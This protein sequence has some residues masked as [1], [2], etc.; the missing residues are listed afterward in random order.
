MTWQTLKE[1]NV[2]FFVNIF[3][4][5][6]IIAVTTLFLLSVVED[7]DF[8]WHLKTGEWIW[9]NKALPS[10]DP[11]AYTTP[12][13]GSA[14]EHAVLTSYWI[15]QVIFHLMHSAAGIS[16]I[17]FLRFLVF[18]A[19]IY[20]MI[21]RRQGDHTLYL[22]LLLIFVATFLQ[23]YVMDR[24]QVFSFLFFG[25]LLLILD[26]IGNGAPTGYYELPI[27]ML[28]WANS[29]GGF[30]LGQV[31]IALYMVMEGVKF[32]K[33][34]MLRPMA[35]EAYKKL[36]LTGAF[37]IACSFVNPNTYHGWAVFIEMPSFMTSQIVEYW[38]TIEYF[39][40]FG[41][42]GIL[43]YWLLLLLT[44]V[45]ILVNIKKIDITE[46]ALLAATGYFS[47]T[48]IRY[49]AFFLIAAVPAAGRLFS[50]NLVLPWAR[51]FILFA[52]I[53]IS[54]FFSKGELH[55]MKN[56][57]SGRWISDYQFPVQAAEFVSSHKLMGNMYNDFGWGGYL[58]WRLGPERK[59]F[60]DGRSLSETVH[61][62]SLR[63]DNMSNTQSFADQLFMKSVFAGYNIRYVIIPFYN[64]YSG[65]MLPLVRALLYNEN[66]VPVFIEKNSTVF[67]K[68]IP[69]HRQVIAKARRFVQKEYFGESM[70]YMLD[71]QIKQ[72]P[73]N[74]RLHI[75][76]G[77]VYL[78][79]KQAQEAKMEYE[80]ALKISPFNT[81]AKERL[82]DLKP[83]EKK[84]RL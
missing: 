9:Q 15:T 54:L 32:L 6:I 47:F 2:F 71:L 22:G 43:P 3:F 17:V 45:G 74:A 56:I 61:A 26:R 50:G 5:A 39:L 51:S 72:D 7:P 46:A 59:V 68:N 23:I 44:A 31:I 12:S 19:L 21:K 70:L 67:V 52:A 64:T 10:H 66:W 1:K 8:F 76:K 60:I 29:H 73:G 4:G 78:F 41:L 79:M 57:S 82:S 40:R 62:R 24:P 16:G 81:M 36:L 48:Q 30:I 34:G 38:S 80:K 37:G 28:L 13:L 35:P 63:I 77:N 25:V 84:E 49:I 20:V 42:Y 58:I 14:R 11:F 27:L 65:D 33:P 18:G 69:E 83:R 53:F 55:N 75:A